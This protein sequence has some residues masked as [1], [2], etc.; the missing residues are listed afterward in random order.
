ML[1]GF[2]RSRSY[3]AGVLAGVLGSLLLLSM[4]WR[5][6][7]H[8]PLY[9]ELLHFFAARG[10][11]DSGLP[12]IADGLYDRAEWF[13]WVVSAAISTLGD[14]LAAARVPSLLASAGLLML[15]AIWVTRRVDFV[16]GVTA[17]VVLCLLPVT[18]DLAVFVRFYTLHALLVLGAAVALYESAVSER[19]WGQ[20]IALVVVA[21]LLLLIA[22]PLQ[23]TTL[24]ASGA[25]AL[26]VG[27]VLLLDYWTVA[28]TFARRNPIRTFGG[29][30][31]AILGGAL[32]LSYF[33][34]ADSFS[35]VPLWASA[36]ANRPLYYLVVIGRDT[37][38]LWPL[39]P[40]AIL[41]S[42]FVN[43]RLT[44]FCVVLFSFALA[45]H[46]VAAS[47]QLRYVYYAVPFFC[48]IWGC[49]LSGL[50]AAGA[51]IGARSSEAGSR[52]AVPVALLVAA[53]V[54]A[55]SQEGQRA[56]RLVLGRLAAD[57]TAIYDGET[58]WGS[59]VPA[60]RPLVSSAERVVTSNS[61]KSLYYFSRYDYELNASIVLSIHRR[62]VR[63]RR[64]HR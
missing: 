44:I 6:L 9:D 36:G 39:F 43:R 19:K 31:L 30:A 25:A 15:L 50:Y 47:K 28:W 33:G 12:K 45:V 21:G 22:F 8:L 57:P 23:V 4:A 63:P 14:T 56:A 48:V 35:Q 52:P 61:M 37:P 10:I 7:Y 58:D 51:R 54:L 26:G 1:L 62:R 29:I 38:L 59:A 16:A 60:L 40:V 18:V 53:V 27:A 2:P 42:F 13:T 34:I 55:L 20:R 3:L 11:R 64:T 5:L 32:G 17:A 41:A 46:S 24:I 49:A